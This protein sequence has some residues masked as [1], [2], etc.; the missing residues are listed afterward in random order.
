MMVETIVTRNGQ[1]TLDK[2]FRKELG[3][4]AGDRVIAN[5]LKGVVMLA[6]K[7]SKVWDRVGSFLPDNFGRVLSKIRSAPAGRLKRVGVL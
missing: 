1:I 7:D 5:K 3:I 6:K 4:A 2:G